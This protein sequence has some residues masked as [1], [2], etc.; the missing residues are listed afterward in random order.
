MSLSLIDVR[1]L[2]GIRINLAKH[3]DILFIILQVTLERLQLCLV[4][5]LNLLKPLYKS[6]GLLGH[7][8]N[9]LIA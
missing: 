3:E 7:I 6:S 4:I 1:R 5:L 9:K 8:V 2:A